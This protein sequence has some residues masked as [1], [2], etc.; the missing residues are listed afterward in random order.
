MPCIY[1]TSNMGEAHLRIA[2]VARGSADLLVHRVASPGMARG[3]ALWYIRRDRQAA[4]V[5]A[6]FTS[7]GMAQLKV[8]FVD[9]YGDAGWQGEKPRHV[10]L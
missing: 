7:L 3:D 10:R 9:S 6:C 2:L 1:Q 5:L 8:C 4:R